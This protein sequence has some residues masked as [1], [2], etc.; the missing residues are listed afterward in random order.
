MK[1]T[2]GR[3]KENEII[4]DNGGFKHAYLAYVAW[5]A[6]NKPEQA[7]PNVPY[8]SRQMFWISMANMWCTKIGSKEQ[9]KSFLINAYSSSEFPVIGPLSNSAEFAK[10]FNCPVGSGMNPINKCNLW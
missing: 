8:T 3:S 1:G 6:A 2:D 7:L 10:D 5:E 9:D 4:A